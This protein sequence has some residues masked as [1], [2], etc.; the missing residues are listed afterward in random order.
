MNITWFKDDSKPG[1]ATFYD[2][3]ITLN[4]VAI[5]NFENYDSVCLGIDYSE[6]QVVIKPCK[7]GTENSFKISIAN[8][9]GRI[10]NKE[11]MKEIMK[12]LDMT[13][14]NPLKLPTQWD[15]KE[16]IL[17]INLKNRG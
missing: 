15:A 12:I 11:F 1:Q 13:F 6:K 8:S 17:V 7:T 9:Y 2:S 4:K 5:K 14:T 3:N 16:G 10:T